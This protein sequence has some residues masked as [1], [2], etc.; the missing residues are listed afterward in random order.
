AGGGR[1]ERVAGVEG[2][3]AGKKHQQGQRPAGRDQ[4]KARE[5]ELYRP[6]P[7]QGL[8]PGCERAAI[9]RG[10]HRSPLLIPQGPSCPSR[11]SCRDNAKASPT[12][13]PGTPILP[14]LYVSCVLGWGILVA[15]EP[16]E[17][18]WDY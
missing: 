18:F 1:R 10:G 12:G 17:S 4:Q 3:G 6:P 15:K 13:V 7:G 5:L 14:R 2:A 9:L 16:T 8:V 11:N